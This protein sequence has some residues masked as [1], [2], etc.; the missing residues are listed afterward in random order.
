MLSWR[1]GYVEDERAC[2]GLCIG[3]SS[4]MGN[5]MARDYGQNELDPRSCTESA[6]LAQALK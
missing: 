3:L 4:G 2:R 6:Q 5:D 1:E